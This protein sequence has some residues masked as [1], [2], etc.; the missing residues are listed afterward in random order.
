[1]NAIDSIMKKVLII[2]ILLLFALA[3]FSQG[4]ADI[5]ENNADEKAVRTVVESLFDGMR[6]GDSTIVRNCFHKAATMQSAFTDKTG[7]PRLES[8]TVDEFC[9]A[10]GTPHDQVWDE[11]IWSYDIKVDGL[12]ASV[13]T[14]YS[15]YLGERKLH[16]G[17]NAFLMYKTEEGWKILRIMDTRRREGCR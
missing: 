8:G 11:K 15:F 9:E 13:W 1:M 5:K 4:E 2:P 12:M 17:V 14:E 6:A 16:C 10:V 7:K 3:S